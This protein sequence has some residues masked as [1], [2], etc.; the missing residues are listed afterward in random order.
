MEQE[1]DPWIKHD[2]GGC[3]LSTGMLVEVVCEDRFGY[4]QNSVGRVDGD[5]YNSWDWS[6]FPELKK[7]VRYRVQRPKGL[8]ILREIAL[9]QNEP[10][11]T[12]PRIPH[13]TSEGRGG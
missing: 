9:D 2:G 1:W 5:S 11:K 8:A 13:T 10:N 3:P 12:K 7:I 4:Q 6:N